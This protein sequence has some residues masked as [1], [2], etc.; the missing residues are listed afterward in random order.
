[1]I[2]NILYNFQLIDY[3]ISAITILIISISFWKGLIQSFLG[4]LTWIGSIII[5]LNFHNSFANFI[6][7]QLNKINFF[8]NCDQL[9]QLFSFILSIPI[10]FLISLIVL[11]R[12]R[13]MISSDI[14]HSS[15][16]IL[17]DKIFGII[18]GLIFSYVILSTMLFF[19]QSNFLNSLVFEDFVNFLIINSHIVNYV[20]EF[21]NLYINPYVPYLYNSNEII[22][23]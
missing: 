19:L 17:L 20:L 12:I 18:Y 9:T 16:G 4:L 22:S 23:D 3:I 13:K 11:R 5:T 2:N 15:Y 1:M 21:N 8:T 14:N 7:S 6:S 10:I